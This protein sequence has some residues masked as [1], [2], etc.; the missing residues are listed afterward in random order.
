MKFEITAA[1]AKATGKGDQPK[2]FDVKRV[3]DFGPGRK[4]YIVED[5]GREWTIWEVRGRVIE[6]EAA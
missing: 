2:T 3:Q 1:W 4:M 6:E 5:N